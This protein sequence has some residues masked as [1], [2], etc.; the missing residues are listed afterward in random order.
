MTALEMDLEKNQYETE[1]QMPG[2]AAANAE[3]E[4]CAV[5]RVGAPAGAAGA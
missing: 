3:D 4:A 1:S 2:S 5:A